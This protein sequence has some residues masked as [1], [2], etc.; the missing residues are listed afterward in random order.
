MI[1]PRSQRGG[2]VR[3]GIRNQVFLAPSPA[4]PLASIL[5]EASEMI[6]PGFLSCLTPLSQDDPRA[7]CKDSAAGQIG[8]PGC[9]CELKGVLGI[10]LFAGSFR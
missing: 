7:P 10:L 6:N 9:I 5:V 3:A 4:L 1:S 8:T 2:N